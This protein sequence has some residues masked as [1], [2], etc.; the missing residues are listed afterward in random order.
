MRAVLVMAAL[1]WAGGACNEGK[2][3]GGGGDLAS[4]RDLASAD[5][6]AAPAP[7][8]AVAPDAAPSDFATPADLSS[9]PADFSGID[10]T[11][12]LSSVMI[13]MNCM[14]SVPPD[15]VSISATLRLTNNGT[16]DVGPVTVTHG[17]VL[18][19]L[20]S[21]ATFSIMPMTTT[22]VIPPGQSATLSIDKIPGTVMPANGCSTLTCNGGVQL[23]IPYSGPNVPPGNRAVSS[24]TLVTCTM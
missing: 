4:A 6:L 13:T 20:A 8:L 17:E 5:D 11:G 14:P 15:P 2:P 16:I 22:G 24:L 1:A 23:S 18:Q 12:S 21:I 3:Q 7:D 19:N 9:P 10:I